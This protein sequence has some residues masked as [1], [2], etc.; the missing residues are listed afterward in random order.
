MTE[1]SSTHNQSTVDSAMS[2]QPW[3]EWTTGTR[4]MV[5]LT[6]PPGSTHLYT[7]VLG[8]IIATSKTTLTLHTRTGDVEVQIA[9]I[10]IGK[11]I[12][13]AP[14]RRRPRSVG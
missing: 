3:L 4:V 14:P 13:P 7:D 10:A 1:L 9:D 8:T 5:R 11:E 12:P 2:P 6:L